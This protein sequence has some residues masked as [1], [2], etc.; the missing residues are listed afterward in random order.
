MNE[1]KN[2]VQ[3]GKRAL[4]CLDARYRAALKEVDQKDEFIKKYLVSRNSAGQAEVARFFEEYKAEFAV[5]ATLELF[6]E[7][8][9]AVEAL[10]GGK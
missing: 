6:L 1:Q 7:E 8:R 5:P 9:R 3:S 2:E 10:R 4:E